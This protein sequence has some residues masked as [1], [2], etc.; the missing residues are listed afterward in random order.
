MVGNTLYVGCRDGQVYA[1]YSESGDEQWTFETG[2]EV[3]SSSSV[4]GGMVFVGSTDGN[5][6]ALAAGVAGSSE[7]S[8]VRQGTHGHHEDWMNSVSLDV[9]VYRTGDGVVDTTGPREAINDWFLEWI[10]LGQVNRVIDAW[11]DG[12]SKD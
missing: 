9:D 11:R 12:E 10:N 6:Y 2:G 5:V 8:R 3:W 1:L 7:G 4:V